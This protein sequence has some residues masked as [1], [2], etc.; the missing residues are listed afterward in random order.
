MTSNVEIANRALDKLGAES[1]V[2]L[3]EDSENARVI[4]RAY[5]SV[6]DSMLR[7]HTWNCAKVRVQ[8]SPLA[9][10]PAF[11]YN[12]QFQLPADCLRPI[13][14]SNV[15]DWSI[16][17]GN[18]LL[19][20]DGNV[21]NLIYVSTLAD[22]NDM[23]SCFIEALASKLALEI[24]EKVTQSATKRKLARDDYD[25]AMATAKKANAYESLPS[26]QDYSSWVSARMTGPGSDP[27]KVQRDN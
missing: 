8:L 15:T 10:A 21:L 6:L 12:Y 5:N 24:C 9:T 7:S 1:I 26:Q 2:S 17:K 25:D 3:T 19:T 18:V 11:D 22:P 4:N 20:N 16:E 23:D 27:M 13:F 14:P